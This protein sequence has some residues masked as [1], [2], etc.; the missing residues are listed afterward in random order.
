VRTGE[1]VAWQ[2]RSRRRIK[3]GGEEVEEHFA[4]EAQTSSNKFSKSTT[5]RNP[6]SA[7]VG[8]LVTRGGGTGAWG[9][10]SVTELSELRVSL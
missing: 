6:G 2:V 4:Q 1:S 5:N 9:W 8:R 3:K 10:C 7:S